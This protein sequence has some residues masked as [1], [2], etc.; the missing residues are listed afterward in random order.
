MSLNRD[1]EQRTKIHEEIAW[2]ENVW[3]PFKQFCQEGRKF[4]IPY[5]LVSSIGNQGHDNGRGQTI[6]DSASHLIKIWFDPN[7]NVSTGISKF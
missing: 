6:K 4:A 3:P 7:Q 5:N 2:N 1:T